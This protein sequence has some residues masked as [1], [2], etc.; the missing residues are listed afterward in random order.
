ML[1]CPLFTP[2]CQN[3]FWQKNKNIGLTAHSVNLLIPTTKNP[4][5]LQQKGFKYHM[6]FFS[7]PTPQHNNPTNGSCQQAEE[8]EELKWEMKKLEAS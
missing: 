5:G 2:R 1:I 8:E 7:N 3:L 4:K 6:A